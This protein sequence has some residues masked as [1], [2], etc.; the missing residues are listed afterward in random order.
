MLNKVNF[1]VYPEKMNCNF[2]T[3]FLRIKHKQNLIV[4]RS[5]TF[6]KFEKAKDE[7]ELPGKYYLIT[8]GYIYSF[9]KDI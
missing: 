9:K 4:L 3:K 2:I 6:T 8:F 7:S 1:F 5:K